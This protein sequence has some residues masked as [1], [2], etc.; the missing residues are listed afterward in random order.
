MLQTDAFCKH[1]MQQNATVAGA[2]LGSYQRSPDPLA[3]CKGAASQRR[4]EEGKG[5]GAERRGAESDGKRREGS[6]DLSV[7]DD[8]EQSVQIRPHEHGGFDDK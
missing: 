3:G 5:E 1:T 4:G 2:P 8:I 6:W 7:T